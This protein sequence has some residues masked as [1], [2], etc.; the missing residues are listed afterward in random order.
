MGLFGKSKGKRV[1]EAN[2]QLQELKG[3]IGDWRDL[4][5]TKEKDVQFRENVHNGF[6]ESLRK[7]IFPTI[8][9]IASIDENVV[10]D[11]E[12]GHRQTVWGPFGKAKGKGIKEGLIRIN[13]MIKMI[14]D[15][16]EDLENIPKD[17]HEW[18]NT[19]VKKL[20]LTILNDLYNIKK[21][22]EE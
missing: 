14:S 17:E 5:L 11:V 18:I 4:V 21:T 2:S 12:T 15:I 3:K 8:L 10:V 6:L 9:V 13:A 1:K 16:T 7:D 22:L 19:E 20:A